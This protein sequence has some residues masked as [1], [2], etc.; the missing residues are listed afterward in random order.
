MGDGVATAA[1]AGRTLADLICNRE[2]ELTALP[3]VGH[4]GPQWEFE[5]LRWLGV[6]AVTALFAWADVSERTLG[7]PSRAASTFWRALGN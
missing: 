5:P 7:R 6:N 3:W 1:L 2:T 4:T